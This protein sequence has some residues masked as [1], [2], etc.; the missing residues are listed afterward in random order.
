MQTSSETLVKRQN[1]LLQDLGEAKDASAFYSE[2][3]DKLRWHLEAEHK[4][5]LEAEGERDEMGQ[6]LQHTEEQFIELS[7][8]LE[9]V[10]AEYAGL[11]EGC[12]R[13]K[14]SHT[15]VCGELEKVRD[16]R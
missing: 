15:K 10:K 5:L 3:N 14:R 13:L 1:V 12:R 8:S 11:L 7:E 16:C 6:R 4:K 2:E 9:Q